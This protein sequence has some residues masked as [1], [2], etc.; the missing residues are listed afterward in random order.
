M[1]TWLKVAY[2]Q[3]AFRAVTL[4]FAVGTCGS[5][6]WA[7]IA[8]STFR[9]ANIPALANAQIPYIVSTCVVS[10]ASLVSFCSF[11][12][13]P[14]PR[15]A[16]Q[17][18]PTLPQTLTPAAARRAP[19]RATLGPPRS[20]TLSSPTT[21]PTCWAWT[22]TLKPAKRRQTS[23]TWSKEPRQLRR[24]IR[25]CASRSPLRHWGP[26]QTLATSTLREIRCVGKKGWQRVV[27]GR[28]GRPAATRW[29]GC[30]PASTRL[31]TIPQVPA[32][33]A[34]HLD[35]A[36]TPNLPLQVMKAIKAANFSSAIIN[37]MVMCFILSPFRSTLLSTH[38]EPLISNLK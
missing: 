24:C 18:S 33:S 4:A 13:L 5:E 3:A 35:H 25:R 12:V 27:R 22:L 1:T 21:P 11:C 9:N 38:F 31:E 2:P 28:L 8:G 7:S 29:A 34:A 19:S 14:T 15:L 6:T 26:R 20:S 23:T 10:L 30:A 17:P 32:W 36:S 37:L 16:A